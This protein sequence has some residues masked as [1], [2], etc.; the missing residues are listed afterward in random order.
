MKYIIEYK[1]DRILINKQYIDN[2]IDLFEKIFEHYKNYDYGIKLEYL[3][4]DVEDI[5][6]TYILSKDY[7]RKKISIKFH[8]YSSSFDSEK[9]LLHIIKI[10]KKDI[11]HFHKIMQKFIKECSKINY[12]F[13]IYIK[14]F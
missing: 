6:N 14:D 2:S 8:Q 9:K 10:V 7:F 13:I 3:S 4:F 11:K 5:C 1:N 12:E